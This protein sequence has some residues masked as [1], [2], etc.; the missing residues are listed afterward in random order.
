MKK[1]ESGVRM[2]VKT[3]KPMLKPGKYVC[4]GYGDT[5][6]MCVVDARETASSFILNV[7]YEASVRL[8]YEGK[9]KII[10]R[11][12]EMEDWDDLS[13]LTREQWLKDFKYIFD[14]C[15]WTC[16]KD[17]RL[18]VKKSGSRHPIYVYSESS[19]GLNPYWSGTIWD[20]ERMEA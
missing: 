4:D 8:F 7:D 2:A 15:N 20:F 6:H 11:Y 14:N 10:R 13:E 9:A 18:T 17:G 16:F 1:D 19:F 12:E 3:V 5:E